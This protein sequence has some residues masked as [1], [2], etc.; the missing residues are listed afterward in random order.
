MRR[1]RGLEPQLDT[2]QHTGSR[3]HGAPKMVAATASSEPNSVS[4]R[5]AHSD[6]MQSVEAAFA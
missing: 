2:P 4:A 3:A 6:I 1:S 5:E